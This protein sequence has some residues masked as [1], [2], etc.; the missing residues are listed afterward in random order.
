M[1]EIRS[2][3]FINKGAELMLLAA[4]QKMRE[5]NPDASFTI[6]PTTRKGSQPFH[7]ITALG[8]YP[9]ADLWKYRVQWGGLAAIVPA[10]IREMF[11][12]VL[13]REVDVVL[14]AAGFAYSDLWGPGST[15]QL[16]KACRRW[17]KTGTKIILLPQAFGPFSS[18]G[19][20]DAIRRVADS[21][22]LLFAREEVSYRHLVEAVGGERP[23]LRMAPDFTNLIEG[24]LPER[25]DFRKLRFCLVPNFRMIDKTTGEQGKNYLLFMAE[26]ARYL[27]EKGQNPF[28]LVHEGEDD[29]RLAKE[30]RKLAGATLPII[31]EDHPL[32]I[33]GIIGV[34]EGMIGSR[35]H[36]LVSAMSQGVP[37]L[38]TGWSHKYRMLFADYGFPE[39]LLNVTLDQDE[40]YG[41]I[42]LIIE[43]RSREKIKSIIK[44][45]SQN[46]MDRSILMWK[47]VFKRINVQDKLNL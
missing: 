27:E 20:K 7:K 1:V 33:K 12:V 5:V 40:I 38:G 21:A 37:T 2:A 14:D 45:N 17:K 42:N 3:G 46:L 30:I 44:K 13:D 9:K 41:K 43:P 24:V 6:A 8:I 39:G 25:Y 28:L 31:L 10:K 47:E 36:G 16:A 22:D 29:L 18:F 11:G 35:F 15:L 26:C 34:S 19:I 23:N 4:L 32:K